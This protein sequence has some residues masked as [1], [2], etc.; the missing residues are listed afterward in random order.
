[1]FSYFISS[2]SMAMRVEESSDNN[3]NTD[4]EDDLLSMVDVKDQNDYTEIFRPRTRACE[5]PRSLMPILPVTALG[6]APRWRRE[7]WVGEGCGV[8]GGVCVSV[9]CIGVSRSPGDVCWPCCSGPSV[10]ASGARNR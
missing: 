3:V 8:Y 10:S 5:Y 9:S 6:S 7:G 2:R 1:M 4:P